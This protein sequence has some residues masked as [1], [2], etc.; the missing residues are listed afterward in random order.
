MPDS[1]QRKKLGVREMLREARCG[2]EGDDDVTVAPE[3]K[4]R[5]TQWL[6]YQFP[7][8]LRH[9]AMPT[10]EQAQQVRNGIRCAQGVQ[11]GSEFVVSERRAGTRH[12]LEGEHERLARKQWEATRKDSSHGAQVKAYEQVFVVGERMCRAKQYQRAHQ[13]RMAGTKSEDDCAAVGVAKKYGF[14]QTKNEYG[15]C[16]NIGEAG[17]AYVCFQGPLGVAGAGKVE[18]HDPA[19]VGQLLH[20]LAKCLTFRDQTMQQYDGRL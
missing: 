6:I 2:R 1:Q 4:R 5:D 10:A 12:S 17:K 15:F 14:V 20:E 7:A 19:V 18:G 16:N 8:E 13:I 9:I 11:I 3:Q